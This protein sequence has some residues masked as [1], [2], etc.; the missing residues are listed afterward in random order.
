MEGRA[1]VWGVSG[2]WVDDFPG[3]VGMRQLQLPA[4]LWHARG[5][6]GHAPHGNA[7]A[8]TAGRPRELSCCS[9]H[10]MVW[11]CQL[12]CTM[13]MTSKKMEAKPSANLTGLPAVEK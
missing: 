9:M 3:R 1:R 6:A 12:T 4:R 5:R 8:R 11:R 10:G 13:K 2:W 7:P